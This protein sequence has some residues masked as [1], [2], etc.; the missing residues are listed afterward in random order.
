MPTEKPIGIHRISVY[1]LHYTT[2]HHTFRTKYTWCGRNTAEALTQWC[3]ALGKKSICL[4]GKCSNTEKG[5]QWRGSIKTSCI[6]WRMLTSLLARSMC[7]ASGLSIQ[8]III[9][10][11]KCCLISSCYGALGERSPKQCVLPPARLAS[12]QQVFSFYGCADSVQVPEH[13]CF[14]K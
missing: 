8:T 2:L 6:H 11:F 10:C 3:C 9:H 5:C 12:F 4:L 13:R 1:T 7:C 14:L